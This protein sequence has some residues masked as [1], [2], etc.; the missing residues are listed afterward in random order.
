MD[1]ALRE[2]ISGVFIVQHNTSTVW[3]N[4]LQRASLI[5]SSS[6]TLH[7]PPPP[8]SWVQ[9]SAPKSK[10]SL[11]VVDFGTPAMPLDPTCKFAHE[12]RKEPSAIDNLT[13]SQWEEQACLLCNVNMELC[14][15]CHFD[16]RILVHDKQNQDSLQSTVCFSTNTKD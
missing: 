7:L 14:N 6:R 13:F 1:R 12:V 11:F 5:K 16:S 15:Q 10:W 3:W 8:T 2:G 4:I 9:D